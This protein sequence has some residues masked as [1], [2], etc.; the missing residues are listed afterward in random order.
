MGEK[1]PKANKKKSV[2]EVL[3]KEVMSINFP[4]VLKHINSQKIHQPQGIKT[5]RKPYLDIA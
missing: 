1:N 3:L 4:N 2:A 5:Q